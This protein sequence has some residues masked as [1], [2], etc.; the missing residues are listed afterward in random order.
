[1]YLDCKLRTIL[2]VKEKQQEIGKWPGLTSAQTEK[3]VEYLASAGLLKV[4]NSKRKRHEYEDHGRRS[5][6]KFQQRMKT[7]S[8]S[9]DACDFESNSTSLVESRLKHSGNNLVLPVPSTSSESEP[10]RTFLLTSLRAN[11]ASLKPWLTG[12]SADELSRLKSRVSPQSFAIIQ[13]L[14]RARTASPLSPSSSPSSSDGSAS[15]SGSEGSSGE[16]FESSSL[17]TTPREG[18]L[19]QDSRNCHPNPGRFCPPFP[20]MSSNSTSSS[21]AAAPP[22]NDH[23]YYSVR[24]RNGA[25]Q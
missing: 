15:D 14:S 3:I 6:K 25:L 18:S 21:A 5:K 17:P 19:V 7:D 1:M 2:L 8:S 10:N 11:L 9:D 24:P 4:A 20:P 13:L 12:C 16:E 22:P 23:D